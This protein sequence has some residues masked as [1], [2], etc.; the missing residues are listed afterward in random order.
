MHLLRNPIAMQKNI[1]ITFAVV[2]VLGAGV[3][4]FTNQSCEGTSC[5]LGKPVTIL[6]D[7]SSREPATSESSNIGAPSQERETVAPSSGSAA[8][9][10]SGATSP[11][12]QPT[13]SGTP[14]APAPEAPVAQ[15]GSY[16]AYSADKIARAETG[17][18]VLFFHA[19][20][21]PSCRGLNSN[22]EANRDDIPASLTILKTDY[23][24]ETALKQK[25][26]VTI[27]HTLVQV[28][29]DGNLIKKWSGG[30]TLT[31]IINQ[32]K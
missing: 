26:G 1:L 13:Q 4:A 25:Y 31:T 12:T 5:E 18:V 3:Y 2:I 29:K 16:E 20:W 17:D 10:A 30:G 9:P 15:A 11:A 21:C 7:T 19:P 28:D 22:I 6:E 23:D 32:I 14:V 27:Q 8:A 24:T